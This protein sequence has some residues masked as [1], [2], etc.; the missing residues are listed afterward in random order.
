MKPEVTS[1]TCRSCTSL[2][3]GMRRERVPDGVGIDPAR[4]GLE[5][6]ARRLA[7]QA[8]ARAHHQRGDEQR[9]HAVGA[10]RSPR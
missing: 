10:A 1:Q 6:H 8:E 5:Q 4:R 9:D 7:E 3:P 2:T